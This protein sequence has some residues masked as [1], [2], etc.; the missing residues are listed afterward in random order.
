MIEYN[1]VDDS[2][3]RNGDFD[4]KFHLKLQYNNR[5]THFNTQDELINGFIS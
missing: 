2:G 1:G 5:I 3:G 4:K